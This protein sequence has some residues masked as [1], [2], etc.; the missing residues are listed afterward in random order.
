MNKIIFEES[1][2]EGMEKKHIERLGTENGKKN[3]DIEK[4]KGL[5]NS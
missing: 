3:Y 2:K 1:E 4:I 5:I